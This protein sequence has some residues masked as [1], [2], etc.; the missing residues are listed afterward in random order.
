[1]TDDL[2]GDGRVDLVVI[3]EQTRELR[4]ALHVV[5]VKRNLLR[6]RHHWI[7]VRL[8][9]EGSGF[10]PLGARVVVTSTR[11][12]Q[13]TQLVT[14]DSYLAQHPTV[15]HF[16]LGAVDRIDAIEVRWT[17]GSTRRLL[18]PEVDRYHTVRGRTAEAGP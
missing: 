3:E 2:D 18:G 1:V 8:R 14:G 15:A 12:R 7:G 16:G 5:H 11:G 9:E 6:T 4:P 10:T 13:V 17:N